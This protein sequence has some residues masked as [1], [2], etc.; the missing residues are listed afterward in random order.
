MIGGYRAHGST[1]IG[2][3][4]RSV[5]FCLLRSVS[6][7]NIHSIT[8][9]YRNKKIAQR[10]W[11]TWKNTSSSLLYSRNPVAFHTFSPATTAPSRPAQIHLN[12]CCSHYKSGAISKYTHHSLTVDQ[13]AL[14]T[15]GLIYILCHIRKQ[16]SWER[17]SARHTDVCY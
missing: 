17:A 8:P 16:W 15:G 10:P 12:R 14:S 6:S 13:W 4:L 11:M 3:S 2:M 5:L 7:L 1:R 9:I